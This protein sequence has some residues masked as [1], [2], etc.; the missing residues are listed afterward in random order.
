MGLVYK[1][2]KCFLTSKHLVRGDSRGERQ[3]A[4]IG[5]VAEASPSFLLEFPSV[6][7]FKCAENIQRI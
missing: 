2:H 1:L 7:A 6:V 4:R 5:P 3:W